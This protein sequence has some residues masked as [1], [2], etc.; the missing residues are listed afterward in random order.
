MNIAVLIAAGGSSSRYLASGGQ[1]PKLEED[2]GGR[3]V[4]IRSVELFTKRHEIAS[5]IV[6]S[7]PEADAR[8]RFELRHADQLAF[9]GVTVCPGGQTRSDSVRAMLEHVPDSST[10]IAVH[11]AARP[12]VDDD[13]LDRLF[14]AAST[15]NAV[16]PGVPIADTI[17]RVRQGE[18]PRADPLDDILG[19]AGKVNASLDEI[20]QTLDR[21]GL[22]AVQTPQVFEIGL[23]RRAYASGAN[24]TD[25][26]GLVEAI[27]EPVIVVAGDP[28]NLKITVPG[29][30]AVAA[31]LLG[32]RKPSLREAHK[33]F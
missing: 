20:T 24:A 16:V 29:D 13:L 27:G 28:K 1:R 3:S 14:D 30:L 7:P 5:I 33:R 31:A 22:V 25:D 17:K 19:D 2:L 18:G 11:D 4:L 10:H 12:L 23:F 9:H 21:E 15:H 6:A 26:A 32:S 8:D